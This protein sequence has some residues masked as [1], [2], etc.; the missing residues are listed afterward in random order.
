MLSKGFD[1]LG[2]FIANRVK[3]EE[4]TEVS[5]NTKENINKAKKA[6]G[7][8]LGFASKQVGRLFKYGK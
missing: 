4:D 8:V 7:T 6:T 3:K 5:D 2:G 1:N